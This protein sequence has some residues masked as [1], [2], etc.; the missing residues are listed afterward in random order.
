VVLGVHRVLFETGVDHLGE[1]VEPKTASKP[2][3][4]EEG[5]G[6]I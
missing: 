5:T 3:K 2:R 6:R 1:P 4:A